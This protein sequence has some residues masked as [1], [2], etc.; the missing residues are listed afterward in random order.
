MAW[1]DDFAAAASDLTAAIAAS[2]NDPADAIRLLLP[3]C[4]WMPD[5]LPGTGALS[6]AARAGREAIAA[7]LRAAAC[8]DLA[9][10]AAAYQPSSYQD[11]QG[12]RTI[13]CAALDAEATRCADAGRDQTWA[14][15]RSLRAA[16]ALD[17]GQRGAS[18]PLL[19]TIRTAQSTPSLA[20]TWTLYQDT[21]REPDL[22]AA[23]DPPHPLFMPLSFPALQK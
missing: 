13:V 15:L 20:E 21:P 1:A 12:L 7:N 19:V 9:R 23:A 14:A 16:V 2:A 17:L 22:V 8:A 11:A 5:S 10:S 4:A 3:L 6:T 18:L